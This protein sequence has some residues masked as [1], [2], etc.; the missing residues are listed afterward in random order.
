MAGRYLSSGSNARTL[1]RLF[2]L[3]L[4]RRRLRAA[5]SITSDPTLNR[6]GTLATPATNRSAALTGCCCTWSRRRTSVA[7][8]SS[9]ESSTSSRR[10]RRTSISVTGGPH[11]AAQRLLVALE[12]GDGFL[13]QGL[14]LL[15]GL[16]EVGDAGAAQHEEGG[17]E[18]AQDRG[19]IFLGGP[20]HQREDREQQP[21][22]H[23]VEAGDGD[24]EEPHRPCLLLGELDGG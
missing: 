17:G 13:E 10:R 15:R 14:A 16:G 22:G 7:R 6:I 11:G 5:R 18:A 23:Q 1:K 20:Q 3:E 21:E 2:S 8:C 12:D 4:M 24:D 19:A 9:A